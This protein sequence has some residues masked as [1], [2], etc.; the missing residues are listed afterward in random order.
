MVALIDTNVVLNYITDREDRFRDSSKI[1]MDLCSQGKVEG[2]IAF[3]S[4]SIIWYSLRIPEDG[5]RMWLKDICRVLTVTG[6]S[7]E[8][9]LDAIDNVQFKDFED[10]LQDEC[11]RMVH[12]D[13]LVTCNLKD[14]GMAKTK[15]CNPDEFIALL[16]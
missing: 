10:C 3:H 1:V 4:L 14:Y 6:A 12:A 2:Y 13:C 7:H 15:V 16:Q 9:V 8:Q 5:K 11:A